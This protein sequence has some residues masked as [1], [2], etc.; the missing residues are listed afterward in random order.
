MFL[1]DLK[2]WIN[3]SH[4]TQN[5]CRPFNPNT[6]QM[7]YRYMHLPHLSLLIESFILTAPKINEGMKI[8]LTS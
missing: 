6:K 3:I 7:S 4:V 1:R 8:L 5:I 2:S